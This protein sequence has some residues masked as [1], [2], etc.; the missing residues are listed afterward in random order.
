MTAQPP[1]NTSDVHCHSESKPTSTEVQ[2]QKLPD[3]KEA[4][5]FLW[6]QTSASLGRD[7][8]VEQFIG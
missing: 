2:S 5:A 8:G 6:E 4:C 7:K 3:F 1:H